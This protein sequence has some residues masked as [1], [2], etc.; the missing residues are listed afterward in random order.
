MKIWPVVSNRAKKL[1]CAVQTAVSNLY[2]GEPQRKMTIK[3]S[4]NCRFLS[5]RSGTFI[6][7]EN[8]PNDVVAYVSMMYFGIILMINGSRDAT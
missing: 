2:G 6:Q 7:H 4:R 8:A 1:Y 3:K 5:P